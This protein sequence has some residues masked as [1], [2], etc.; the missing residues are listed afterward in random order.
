MNTNK[1]TKDYFYGYYKSKKHAAFTLAEVLITLGIIGVVAAMTIP[2]LMAKYQKEQTVT[3]L[4]R[5]IS[6]LNQAYKLSFDEN[7]DASSK[8][9]YDMGSEAYLNKYWTPYIKINTI[10]K[11]YADC[12]YKSI[13]PF[14]FYDGSTCGWQIINENA[15]IGITT[16]DGFTYIIFTARFTDA[17]GSTIPGT[18]VWVDING[19]EGPNQIGRDVFWLVRAEDKGVFPKGFDKSDDYVNKNCKGKGDNT[20]AEKIRRAGWKIEKDYPW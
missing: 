15:R 19:S 9:A 3:K 14:K 18:D 12:G 8:E 20:C 5:A 17:V 1:F 2:A 6:V 7:G 11:T 16:M 13:T 10:C 4:K